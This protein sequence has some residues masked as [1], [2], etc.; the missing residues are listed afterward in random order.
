MKPHILL[1]SGLLIASVAYTQQATTPKAYFEK[2]LVD[3]PDAPPPPYGTLLRVVDSVGASSAGEIEV[4]LPLISS[5]LKSNVPNLPIEGVFAL[6]AIAQRPDGGKLLSGT[7]P[8]IASLM[9]HLDE[10]ISGGSVTILRNLTRT[11][12]DSTVPLLVNRLVAP[13][14]PTLVKSEIVRSL[15]E[16]SK[17]NEQQVLKSIEAYLT[18]DSAPTVKIATLGAIASNR[19]QTPAIATY[20][21]GGLNDK[22]K[23]V[24]IAAIQAVYALGQD[25]RDKAG[26]RISQLATGQTVDAQ[27]RAVAERALQNRLG[28]PHKVELPPPP[29]R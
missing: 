7:L 1:A 3:R 24:Q 25:V 10:R 14:A 27:V 23:H 28:E 19:F 8:E 9:R 12:P 18:L 13:G 17:R 26:P 21:L 6:F 5:A 29:K 2:R 16:S 22:D 11:I 4:I 20:A 15:L